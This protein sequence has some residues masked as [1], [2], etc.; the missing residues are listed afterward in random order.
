M[1][2]LSPV[3]QWLPMEQPIAR[4]SDSVIADAICSLSIADNCEASEESKY[5]RGGHTEAPAFG[6][7]SASK[8][9]E[10][11]G[12][13][14]EEDELWRP[15]PKVAAGASAGAA[16]GGKSN[17]LCEQGVLALQGNLQVTGKVVFILEANHRVSNSSGDAMGVDPSVRRLFLR[18]LRFRSSRRAG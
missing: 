13:Q 12:T 4:S 17:N 9:R 8:T 16:A 1:I 6:L 14:P 15:S 5:T 10:G 2:E 7:P 18:L 3:T 11:T